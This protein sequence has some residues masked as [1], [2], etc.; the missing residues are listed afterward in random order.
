MT[1]PKPDHLAQVTGQSQPTGVKDVS[2]QHPRQV[3]LIERGATD[4][5]LSISS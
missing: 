4:F 1:R 3:A 2:K 5:D